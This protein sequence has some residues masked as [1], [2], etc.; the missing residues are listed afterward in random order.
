MELNEDE[1]NIE[2]ALTKK[3]ITKE[4]NI[5]SLTSKYLELMKVFNIS[6]STRDELKNIIDE[7]LNEIDLIEINTLKAKNIEKLKEKEK[8][9]YCEEK[10]KISDKI[11]KKKEEIVKKKKDLYDA[12][13]YRNNL[14]K[15]EEIAKN[16]NKY[17]SPNKLNEK[18]NKVMNENANIIENIKEFDKKLGEKENKMNK[19]LKLINELK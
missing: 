6:T 5:K 4:N 9:I 10:T 11:N 16:I 3:I 12:K 8:K 18:K 15:C 13:N 2:I 19:I 17:D 1:K 14:I 7:I